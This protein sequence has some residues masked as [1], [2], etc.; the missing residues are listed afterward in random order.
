MLID[1]TWLRSTLHSV[2]VKTKIKIVRLQ[3]QPSPAGPAQLCVTFQLI[4]DV[5]QMWALVKS[6]TMSK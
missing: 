5:F 1:L 3:V 6:T 2:K 4:D